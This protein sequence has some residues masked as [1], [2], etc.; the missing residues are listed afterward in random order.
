MVD[1]GFHSIFFVLRLLCLSVAIN[2]RF[3]DKYS[4]GGAM[5]C[6]GNLARAFSPHSV[7]QFVTWGVYVWSVIAARAKIG[8]G[9]AALPLPLPP[10]RTGG[11]PASGFPVSGVA[12]RRGRIRFTMCH[13][14]HVTLLR[15]GCSPPAASHLVSPRRSSLR[16]QAG[17][18]SA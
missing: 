3:Q 8:V 10:N 5:S 7:F 4:L 11:F 12:G 15:T 14:R 1:N 6:S 16:L 13:V 18:R 9:G 17:E 2:C